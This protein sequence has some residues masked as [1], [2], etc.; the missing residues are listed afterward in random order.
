MLYKSMTYSSIGMGPPTLA[1]AFCIGLSL[2]EKF[3]K[4]QTVATKHKPT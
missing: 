4:T 1:L 2:S 3:I